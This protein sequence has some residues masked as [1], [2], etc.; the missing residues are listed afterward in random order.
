MEIIRKFCEKISR[1]DELR[2]ENE[3]LRTQVHNR[4]I[5]LKR[6]KIIATG[7]HYGYSEADKAYRE[8]NCINYKTRRI[9]ELAGEFDK[10]DKIDFWDQLGELEE[11]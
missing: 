1:I 2:K 6:I 4:D 5:I 9:F 10:D 3:F 7:N 11:E 8:E